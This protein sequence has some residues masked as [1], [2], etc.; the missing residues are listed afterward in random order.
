MLRMLVGV[1]KLVGELLSW[2]WWK[3]GGWNLWGGDQ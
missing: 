3:L 1:M 2:L